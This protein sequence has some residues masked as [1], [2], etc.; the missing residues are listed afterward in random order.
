MPCPWSYKGLCG[1]AVFPDI[2]WLLSNL[3]RNLVNMYSQAIFLCM[4]TIQVGYGE[5]LVAKLELVQF[6]YKVN[7][8]T[9]YIHEMFSCNAFYFS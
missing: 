8:V 5:D 2:I 4:Q 1:I 9:G 6:H 7:T 3:S